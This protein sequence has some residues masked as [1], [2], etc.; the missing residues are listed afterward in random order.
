MVPLNVSFQMTFSGMVPQF[1]CESSDGG[2]DLGFSQLPVN[3]T[4][5]ECL[6][7]LNVSFTS[8]D[9]A[10]CMTFNYTSPYKTV[11]KDV[12]E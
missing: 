6:V 8:S 5:N 3:V 1:T 4:T 7:P 12:S 9:K 11:M 2:D 10:E